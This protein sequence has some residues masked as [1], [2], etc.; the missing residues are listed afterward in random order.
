MNEAPTWVV[1][2][3]R[4]AVAV[5]LAVALPIAINTAVESTYGR[6]LPDDRK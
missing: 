3:A 6:R 4:I 5:V 1:P 2:A